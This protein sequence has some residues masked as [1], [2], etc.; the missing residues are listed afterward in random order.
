MIRAILSGAKTQ[1]RRIVKMRCGT[2]PDCSKPPLS[3]HACG[4]IFHFWN[5]GEVACPYG[6]TGDR[7][8]VREAFT[9]LALSGYPECFVYRADG[10]HS[11]G[12]GIGCSLPDGVRWHPSIH[13]PRRACRLELR[14]NSIRV[15]RLQDISEEDAAAEGV[16][17]HR[18]TGPPPAWMSTAP[19]G[20]KIVKYESYVKPFHTLWE[21]INGPG[22]WDKN[23]FVWVVG[24]SV[25][26]PIHSEP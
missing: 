5:Y 16:E 24:F 14:V 1:T 3:T 19:V 15:E 26:P 8:W 23:P 4:S 18:E 13:M 6:A 7:L 12:D 11:E 20:T 9:N 17:A 21:S 10:T 22:S 2:L 25:A